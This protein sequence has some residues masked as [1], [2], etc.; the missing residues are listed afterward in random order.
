M[1]QQNDILFSSLPDAQ[2]WQA[3]HGG[4]METYAA[5]DDYPIILVTAVSPKQAYE[6]LNNYISGRYLDRW[7]AGGYVVAKYTGK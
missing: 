1:T 3:E 4:V 7:I 5:M 6:K 2:A